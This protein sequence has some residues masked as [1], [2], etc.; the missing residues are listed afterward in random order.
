MNAALREFAAKGYA[1]AR[2]DVI[3]ARARVNKRLLYHYFGNK[4]ALFREVMRRKVVEKTE[5]VLAAPN[6]AL[7]LLPYWYRAVCDDGEW[8]RLVQWEA[9]Q[10]PPELVEETSRREELGQALAKLRQG[11]RQGLVTPHLGAE[12]LLLAMLALTT[13]PQ[14]YPQMV[15]L[16]TG[17][18]HDSPEFRARWEGC[19][20]VLGRLLRERGTPDPV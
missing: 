2:V 4:D 12:E 7:A 15:R 18:A 16:I 19:L 6:D 11:Q 9:L 13:Y 3:A 17:Q 14:T 5:T 10:P 1:G 8:L 20:D